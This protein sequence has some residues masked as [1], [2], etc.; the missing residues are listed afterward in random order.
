LVRV[1]PPWIR[2]VCRSLV[3]A[4]VGIPAGRAADRFGSQGMTVAGLLGLGAGAAILRVMPSKDGVSGYVIPLAAMTPSYAVF[5]AADNTVL[6]TRIGQD[7]RGGA[8][9]WSVWPAIS[10]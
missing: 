7:R 5:E 6:M 9:A 10:D 2:L 1:P 3:A 4:L 8:P